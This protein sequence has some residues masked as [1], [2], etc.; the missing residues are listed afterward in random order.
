MEAGTVPK[1]NTRP[2]LDAEQLLSL[3]PQLRD[4]LKDVHQVEL[5]NFSMEIG[6]LELFIPTSGFASPAN[7]A[8][9]AS[10]HIPEKPS[11]LIR[12][13]YAP[14][15]FEFPGRIREVTLGATR[16]GEGSRGKS[17]TIGGA[18]TPAYSDLIHL[19]VHPPA[20]SLDV[21]DMKVSLPKFLRENVSEVME[22]P[23]E[24]A[25]MNVKNYGADVVTI[26]LMST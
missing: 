13:S 1:K 26:H 22:D 15:G 14:S 17:I 19:P 12:E 6:D 10:Q 24:W 5:K 23:A 11:E 7:L 3:A 20:I 18:Q 16:S 4:M 9:P 25:R 8:H 21:F 2:T